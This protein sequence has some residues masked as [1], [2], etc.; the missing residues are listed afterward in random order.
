MILK[1]EH[2]KGAYQ[3]NNNILDNINLELNKNDILAL[4]GQNGAGKSTLAKAIIN[5]LPYRSGKIIFEG[6][7]ISK[8]NTRQLNKAGIAYFMQ[9]GRVF[10]DLSIKENIIFALLNTDNEINEEEFVEKYPYLKKHWNDEAGLLSGG[11]RHQ[12]ALAMIL[13]KKPKLLILDEPTAG[14]SPT[15]SDKMYNLLNTLKNE[16]DLIIIIEQNIGKAIAFSNKTAVM[17]NGEIKT[18]LKSEK[19]TIQKI[20]DIWFNNK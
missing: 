14:L 16:T 8:L 20:Q 10:S 1:L 9:G 6:K 11:E 15:A 2:I 5:M 7:D 13:A 3:K 4:T 17:Q 12:L 19:E 18:V